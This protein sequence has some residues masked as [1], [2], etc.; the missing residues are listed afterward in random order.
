MS[1]DE[2]ILTHILKCSRSQL[3]AKP[4]KLNPQQQRLYQQCKVRRQ[5]GEPLQYIIGEWEF[6]GQRLKTDERA[7]VPRP[8]TEMLVD[9]AIKHFKGVDILDLGTGS[10]NIVV[11]LA[12]F[13]PYTKI[14]AVDV[15]LNALELALENIQ[16]HGLE[17][18]VELLHED[19]KDFLSA[20]PK[21]FDLIISNPPYIPTKQMTSLPKD[22]LCEP[23]LALEGGADGLDY[24]RLIIKQTPRLLRAG[25]CLMMEFGDGQA[26]AIKELA[27]HE[28]QFS[29]VEIHKDLT[30]RERV[31][32]CV[33]G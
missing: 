20:C 9:L 24:C 10:G 12:K 22:V 2:I 32:V 7:L 23:H 14:T 13:L 5:K 26:K 16:A 19:M 18:R 1:E 30:G 29:S 3:L 4:P 11:S 28:K 15:S 31:L 8:E 27:E 17:G 21:Q 6:Y 25:A 33:K